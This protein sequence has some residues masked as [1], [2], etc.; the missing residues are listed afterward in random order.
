MDNQNLNKP[1]PAPQT[2]QVPVEQLPKKSPMATIKQGL[3]KVK[4]SPLLS[5]ASSK[6]ESFPPQQRRLLKI[7][8]GVFAFAII[9]LIIGNIVKSLRFKK[10]VS[11]PTPTP[12]VQTP[13]PTPSSIGNPSV[14]ATDSGVLKIESDLKILENKLGATDLDESNLRPPDINFYVNFNQ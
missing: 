3:E 1:S 10:P 2:Q 5:Q 13:L 4:T 14:Y 6:F 9:L 12:N 11:T 8:A 7:G